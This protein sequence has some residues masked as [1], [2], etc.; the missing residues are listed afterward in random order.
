MVITSATPVICK[1]RL[2]IPPCRFP[3]QVLDSTPRG[4]DRGDLCCALYRM[5]VTC[6]TMLGVLF[7]DYSALIAFLGRAL[8]ASPLVS[9]PALRKYF[10]RLG[11]TPRRAFDRLTSASFNQPSSQAAVRDVNVLSITVH[12]VR[13]TAPIR[14]LCLQSLSF[15]PECD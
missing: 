9:L 2:P 10:T 7:V 11:R 6:A 3:L 5:A 14:V 8:S 13:R 12:D 15:L 4:N 1:A